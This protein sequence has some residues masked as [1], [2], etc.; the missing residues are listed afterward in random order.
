[1]VRVVDG[2]NIDVLVD[3]AKQRVRHIGID[4]PET[5]HPTRGGGLN[6]RE[7]SERNR[8]LVLG[9]TV[10]LEK[11]VSETDR[12]G[13]ILRY[14][15]VN[16]DT[17]VNAVLVAEGYAQV[18]TYPP[19]VKYADQF[20]QLQR[21]ARAAGRGLWGQ[22]PA[23]PTPKA[24]PHQVCHPSYEGACLDPNASDYD[25]AGGSGDGPLYT[26]RV[27]VVGPDVFGLD[28]DGDGIG[29]Q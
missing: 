2:D 28:R 14:V 21:E 16:D 9:Q 29:C 17:M 3:R 18:S 13:R 22:A 6:G 7:A 24:A 15:W 5:V 23:T 4:T 1:M 8:E 10:Y 27:R 12:Y 19:D 26:G 11:D 25:C 20:L